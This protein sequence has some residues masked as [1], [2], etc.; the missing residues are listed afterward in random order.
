M[1]ALLSLTACAYAAQSGKPQRVHCVC[2]RT[3]SNLAGEFCHFLREVAGRT[4]GL[5]AT[6]GGVVWAGSCTSA[7]QRYRGWWSWCGAWQ[8]GMGSTVLA[9]SGFTSSGDTEGALLSWPER[10][11]PSPPS[12]WEQ[13]LQRSLL[14]SWVWLGPISL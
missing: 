6:G 3:A 7:V 13:K 1:S 11:P 8:V 9:A 12:P 2:G 14:A 4:A 5:L 10:L